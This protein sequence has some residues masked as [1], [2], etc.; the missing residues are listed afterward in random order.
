MP[1][2][3]LLIITNPGE[4][5]VYEYPQRGSL[6]EIAHIDIQV[7][8]DSILDSIE[9]AF[10][11]LDHPQAISIIQ[12]LRDYARECGGLRRVIGYS[13]SSHLKIRELIELADSV[14]NAGAEF[15]LFSP[16]SEVR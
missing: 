14:E 7:P 4:A 5:C 3:N 9:V 15:L 10:V 2:K 11:N 13:N 8:Q 16:Y 1:S 12:E 6:G